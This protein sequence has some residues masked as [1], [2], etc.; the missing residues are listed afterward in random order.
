MIQVCQAIQHA[1]QKGIIHRDIKPSNVLVTTYNGKAVPKVIDF[2]IAKAIADL[3][4]HIPGVTH[5][6]VIM[7][8]FEFMSPE[9][10]EGGAT[11]VDTRADVYS[12][13]ALLYLL[14][15]GQ[16]PIPGLSLDELTY[17]EVLSRIREQSPRPVS[18]QTGNSEL[19]ELDW[20]LARAL[21]KDRA[22]RYQTA[23]AL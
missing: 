19:Y 9:Q 5:A 13:G 12:L 17:S 16:A 23:E 10:A 1:H 3:P 21:E 6:G 4:A 2:G 11:D 20:I 14:V 8:T 18:L 22:Q 15:C 7:G